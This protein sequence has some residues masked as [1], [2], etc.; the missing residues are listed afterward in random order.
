MNTIEK[1]KQLI[2]QQ[3]DVDAATID[4]DAPFATYN[5]DSLTLVE[6]IFSIEDTFHVE[7]PDTAAR[8]VTTLRGLAELLDE[9]VAVPVA[10][11]R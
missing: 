2:N 3:F 11:A 5:I 9:L 6:L 8:T 4:A 10:T 1:L 7:V